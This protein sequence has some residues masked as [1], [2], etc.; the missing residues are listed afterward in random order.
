MRSFEVVIVFAALMALVALVAVA[1]DWVGKP[2]RHRR[3]IPRLYRYEDEL[4][5]ELQPAPVGVALEAPAPAQPVRADT[6]RRARR[7]A[8]RARPAPADQAEPAVAVA[9][10]VLAPGP[11]VMPTAPPMAGAPAAFSANLAPEAPAF[12]QATRSQIAGRGDT[13]PPSTADKWQPGLPL[14]T[15]LNSR[16]PTVAVKA[17]RYWISLGAQLTPG[18]HFDDEMKSEML[19]GRAPSRRNPRTGRS[20]RM[21]LEGLRSASS[22]DDVRMHWPDAAVDPWS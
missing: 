21:Q 20:E 15:L 14:D 16:K 11:V 6:S 17:E 9:P 8:R 4:P 1:I 2:L 7:G 19:S 3:F 18:S 13:A 5:F 10:S 22:L 12:A